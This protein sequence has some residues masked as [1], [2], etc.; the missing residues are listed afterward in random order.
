[1]R[2]TQAVEFEQHLACVTRP[3]WPIGSVRFQL[4]SRCVAAAGCMIVQ[5]SKKF[6]SS[7]T[8]NVAVWHLKM[9]RSMRG[10][11]DFAFDC[12]WRL[13]KWEK[14]HSWWMI[15]I[16]ITTQT[17]FLGQPALVNR[18][19]TLGDIHFHSPTEELSG[20][21]C[22]VM[23]SP[24]TFGV[25]ADWLRCETTSSPN[26]GRPFCPPQSS[27]CAPQHPHWWDECN[28]ED[29]LYRLTVSGEEGKDVPLLSS[30]RPSV[31][32]S[33]VTSRTVLKNLA[34]QRSCICLSDVSH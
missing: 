22:R 31:S 33:P 21:I 25:I 3:C 23:S 19:C 6:R 12:R 20:T 5:T 24:R 10:K 1:M 11:T 13:V 8:V 30:T 16:Y 26:D 28:C 32:L 2:I 14:L 17:P 4:S 27:E 34:P 18:A 9:G 15:L 7:A 29:S